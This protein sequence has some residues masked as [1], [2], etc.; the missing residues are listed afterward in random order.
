M[1]T[2]VDDY[3]AGIDTDH[4]ALFDRI[5]ALIVAARPDASA[6]IS[7]GIPTFEVGRRRL[8]VGAWKHGISLYGWGQGHDGGFAERHPSLVTGKGTIRLRPAD[9]DGITDDELRALIEGA[10]GAGA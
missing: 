3:I 7:Y 5:H 10:L 4:R 6:R 2:E 8:Y 9:A 1:T